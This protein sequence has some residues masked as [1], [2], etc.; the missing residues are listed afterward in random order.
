MS[1]GNLFGVLG[2]AA[3]TAETSAPEATAK[4]SP[5]TPLTPIIGDGGEG[6]RSE[7]CASLSPPAGSSCSSFT[8]SNA[9]LAIPAPLAALAAR[10][11][12]G[13]RSPASYS[14]LS[15]CLD[16]MSLPVD[17]ETLL[18]ETDLKR[19]EVWQESRSQDKLCQ[20]FYQSHHCKHQVETISTELLTLLLNMLHC[21][22]S[23]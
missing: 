15:S 6:W 19:D 23:K 17:P 20:Y 18:H 11:C 4:D 1:P 2:A 9:R 7:C 21:C 10:P 12:R 5:L 22:L 13:E 16:M 8:L 14:S 3:A